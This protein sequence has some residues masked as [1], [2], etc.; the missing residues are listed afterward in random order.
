MFII[1]R[2]KLR[3]N[4]A[5]TEILCIIIFISICYQIVGYSLGAEFE[6]AAKEG[7]IL[8][9]KMTFGNET[10]YSKYEINK[11]VELSDSFTI[12]YNGY[13][14]D[15]LTGLNETDVGYTNSTITGKISEDLFGSRNLLTLI[16]PMGTNF[17]DSE[18]EL[19]NY[20]DD[21]EDITVVFTVGPSG[22]SINIA[23]YIWVVVL[24]K[25]VEFT[26]Y[27]STTG[28]LLLG[29]FEFK[30]PTSSE[31]STG[32]YE[33]LPEHSTILGADENPYN[34]ANIPGLD[35]T[36]E[37]QFPDKKAIQLDAK[38]IITIVLGSLGFIG[39]VWLSVYLIKRRRKY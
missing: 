30:D 31:E 29:D 23:F 24:V 12:Y 15:N 18:I 34:P 5:R 8:M 11:T 28:V 25:V 35:S 4:H 3:K 38:G 19:Q 37:D 9:Y 26:Y 17:S 22:Y 27:Y 14:A 16:L 13:F 1:D 36:G 6:I 20:F 39:L 33:I 7:D 21:I 2:L 10:S 32:K